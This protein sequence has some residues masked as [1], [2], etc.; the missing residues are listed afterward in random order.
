MQQYVL[1]LQQYFIINVFVLTSVSKTEPLHCCA[2]VQIG[3]EIF[4]YIGIELDLYFYSVVLFTI[5][6]S[7]RR[8]IFNYE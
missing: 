2:W 3:F 5:V 7:W 6:K 8:V 4:T 1:F